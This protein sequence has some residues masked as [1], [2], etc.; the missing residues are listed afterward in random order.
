M[1]RD[2][3]L[4]PLSRQHQHAL[5]LCV[6]IDRASISE[7]D[8]NAWQ[9]EI[10]QA[11]QSE[12]RIHFAAEEHVLFPAANKFEELNPLVGELLADH[13]VLRKYFA[14]AEARQM[15]AKSL[16]DFARQ[17][18][19]HIRKEERLLFEGVQRLMSPEEL[20]LL[21]RNLETA[22]TD[23]AQICRLP[24]EAIKLRSAKQP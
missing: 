9:A 7:A 18:S 11:F 12:I 4:I 3:N 6:R 20:E 13:D 10:T 2:K 17:M 24:S 1:L 5:A 19:T 8:L 22:L 21:G 23:A 16:S 14:Q 15:S